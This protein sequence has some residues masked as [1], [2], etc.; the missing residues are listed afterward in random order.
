MIHLL[1]RIVKNK[2]LTLTNILMH[3]VY[4]IIAKQA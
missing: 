1:R 3:N 4:Y 2:P